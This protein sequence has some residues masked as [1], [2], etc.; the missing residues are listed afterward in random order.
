MRALTNLD[1]T[2]TGVFG[3]W[4]FPVFV[5]SALASF[6]LLVGALVALPAGLGPA[7]AFAETF[8]VWCFGLDPRTGEMNG[9]AV[10]TML[11]EPLVLAAVVF[12]VW[13]GPLREARALPARR[14]GPTIASA[15][16][17][18]LLTIG[19][20][21]AL[22]RAS[23]AEAAAPFR[24]ASLRTALPAPRIALLSHEGVPASLEAERGK[25]VLLTA[26]YAGC[27]QACPKIM[28]QVRRAA[29]ALGAHENGRDL[30]VL[31]VTLDPE[32]DT[33]A[34]LADLARAQ[35]IGAPLFRLLTGPP[36]DVNRVLDDMGIAR[37]RD[38]ETGVIDHVNMFIL[39]DRDGRL[40]YRFGLGED[41]ERWLIECGSGLL[42]ERPTT[43]P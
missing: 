30:R 16:A 13:R 22:E 18:V 33:P 25:V 40:A 4:R 17:L 14:L 32:R 9:A 42:S 28:A 36:E 3:G 26:V 41:Q 12:A 5:L 2:M 35:R 29:A 21:F 31:A 34:V 23:E 7:G 43:R 38:P 24:P 37:R 19:T 10:F 8:R 27:G 39:I 20:L 6:T 1:E 15:L 11:T